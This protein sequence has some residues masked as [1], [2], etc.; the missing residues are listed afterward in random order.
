M[1][2]MSENKTPKNVEYMCSWC[3][4]KA[5]THVSAGRPNPGHCPRKPKMANG[6]M[7]PHTWV[8]KRKF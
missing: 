2:K 1:S 8:I 4:A 6:M 7:K 5:V 3:G